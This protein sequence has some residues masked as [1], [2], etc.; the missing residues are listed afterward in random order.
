[1]N[2]GFGFLRPL[3]V[4]INNSN[5]LA[6]KAPVDLYAA[7]TAI[8]TKLEAAP[9][10]SEQLVAPQIDENKLAI[11]DI[12]ADNSGREAHFAGQVAG[13]LNEQAPVLVAG[14]VAW[15][16]GRQALSRPP[17]REGKKRRPRE[18]F[19]GENSMNTS[20][21]VASY[22]RL[23][24]IPRHRLTSGKKGSRDNVI[25]S[26]TADFWYHDTRGTGASAI[27]A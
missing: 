12:F 16:R 27:I 18:G 19:Q 7:T 22:W 26:H 3:V 10:Q 5:V 21:K 15:R 1:M 23:I 17:E 13:L 8:Y 9:G 20:V 2:V 4:N 6:V 25:T 24:C 11:F 14:G